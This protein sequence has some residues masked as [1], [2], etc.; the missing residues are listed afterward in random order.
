MKPFRVKTGPKYGKG[1]KS[2]ANESN[3][4]DPMRT[5]RAVDEYL[6][7]RDIPNSSIQF[8]FLMGNA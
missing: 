7:L 8:C 4:N 6:Q 1:D 3:A 5:C 2:H